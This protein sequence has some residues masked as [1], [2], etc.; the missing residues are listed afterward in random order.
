MAHVDD[1]MRDMIWDHILR[2]ALDVDLYKD[3]TAYVNGQL[4]EQLTSTRTS[5]PQ[6]SKDFKVICTHLHSSCIQS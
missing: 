5:V 2:L 1:N 6:V 4:L 3:G